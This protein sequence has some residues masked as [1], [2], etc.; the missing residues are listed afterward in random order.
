MKLEHPRIFFVAVFLAAAICLNGCAKKNEG[1]KTILT[2]LTPQ[3]REVLRIQT[4]VVRHFEKERPEI[5]INLLSV[6]GARHSEKLKTMIA[7]NTPPDVTEIRNLEFPAFAEKG[8]LLDLSP[9]LQKEPK[10]FLDDFNPIAVN[11]SS[12]KKK[13]Y[14]FTYGVECV[15]LFY[16]QDL[17]DK[18]GV[19][20]PDESWTW[21]DLLKACEKLTR[22]S[23]QNSQFGIWPPSAGWEGFAPLVWQ[24]GGKVFDDVE[25]PTKCLI[26]QPAA[27]EALQF[28]VDI[29]RKYHYAPTTSEGADQGRIEMFMSGRIGMIFDGPWQ[30]PE[31]R[32]L[33]FRWDVA[34]LPKQK[35]R[36]TW[37]GSSCYSVI[38]GSKHPD[39][40]YEFIKFLTNTENQRIFA[41]VGFSVP[42]RKSA[43]DAYLNP[44]LPPKNQRILIEL[45]DARM[46]EKTAKYEEIKMIFQQN[47]EPVFL[48]Q[49]PLHE[50]C[51]RIVP[52]VNA[53]LKNNKD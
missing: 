50:A 13:I 15:F 6:P 30:L 19:K 12:Y 17:F 48:G 44:A 49:K 43:M 27:V 16:N 3:S 23:G 10:G 46:L 18:S 53:L 11:L 35:Y 8:I 28:L 52:E 22:R 5:K 42:S 40:A 7:G 38:K 29:R 1:G 14:G 25:N 34:V 9:Y 31:F 2:F 32:K 47:L 21:T 24:N 33:K 26:N 20:Y 4:E 39:E 45:K 41:K 37:A 51:D 36:A